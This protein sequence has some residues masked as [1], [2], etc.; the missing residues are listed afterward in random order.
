M[1][2]EVHHVNI[3]IPY[4]TA[5]GTSVHMMLP[6]PGTA[7][8][9]GITLARAR[10]CSNVAIGAGTSP[11]IRLVTMTSAGAIIA[12]VGANGS[13]ALTA[14]TPITGTISTYWIPG[15]VGYL[16]LQVGHEVSG[17]NNFPALSAS[18]EYFYGRGSA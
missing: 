1:S 12:T 9:G 16:G 13:A 8:G 14:G 17:E 4:G 3:S 18:V 2:Q 11:A 10:Y 5:V 6:I 7:F 15:T